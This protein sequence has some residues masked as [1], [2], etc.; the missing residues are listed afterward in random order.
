MCEGRNAQVLLDNNH[1]EAIMLIYIR[2][3]KCKLAA[4]KEDSSSIGLVL[5]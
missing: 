1:R 4:R 5:G 3:I 2:L